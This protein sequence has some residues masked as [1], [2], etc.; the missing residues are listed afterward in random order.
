[1]QAAVQAVQ[2]VAAWVLH[3]SLGLLLVETPSFSCCHG[4]KSPFAGATQALQSSPERR[5]LGVDLSVLVLH[6]PARRDFVF[7]CY[8]R[9][10]L[11]G[12]K[13]F[14]EPLVVFR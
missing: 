14:C 13:T 11:D 3:S 7:G 6:V 8:G 5:A 10:Y 2:H 1:M 4:L 9:V 12:L